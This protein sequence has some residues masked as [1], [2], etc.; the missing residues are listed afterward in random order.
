MRLGELAEKIGGKIITHR[1]KAG[2]PEVD[3]VYAGDRVSDMLN[4]ASDK[5]LLVTNLTN[6]VLVRVAELMDTPGICLLNGNDPEPALLN[7]AAEHGT[8][9]MVSPVGMFETCGRLYGCL[10]RESKTGS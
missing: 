7:A 6:A 9:V 2:T 3:H 5:T 10:A 1:D 4:E 8:A